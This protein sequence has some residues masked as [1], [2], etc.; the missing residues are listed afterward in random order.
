M[1]SVCSAFSFS[2]SLIFVKICVTSWRSAWKT[3]RI[4]F[5]D[6]SGSDSLISDIVPARR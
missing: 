6:C 3:S 5:S 1:T 2:S 4:Y